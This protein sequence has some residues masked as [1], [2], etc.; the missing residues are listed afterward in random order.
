MEDEDS[1]RKGGAVKRMLEM[2]KSGEAAQAQ[3]ALLQ[4]FIEGE[5][6]PAS[7]LTLSDDYTTNLEETKEGFQCEAYFP[8]QMLTPYAQA[9]GERLENGLIRVKLEVKLEDIVAIAVAT[10]SGPQ[11]MLYTLSGDEE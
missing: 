3:V 6:Y 7:A 2:L 10:E 11:T 1:A 9:V 8:D 4:Y 5:S